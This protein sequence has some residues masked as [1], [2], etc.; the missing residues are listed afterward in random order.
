MEPGKYLCIDESMCQWLGK[1]MPNIK[2]VPRKP[3]PIGQEYK[4]IADSDTY[5]ILRLDFVSDKF[6]KKFDDTNRTLV[7]TVKRLTE[8][9]F[10]SGRT[11]IADSWFGSPELQDEMRYHGLYSIMQV[12]K[13]RYWPRGMPKDVD[14]ISDLGK[15]FGSTLSMVRITETGGVLIAAS[16]RDKKVKAIVGTCSTTT[17]ASNKRTFRDANGRK[18]TID[19]PRIFDEYETKKSKCFFN[20]NKL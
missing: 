4:T 7:A 9:W 3:H 11:L 20:L 15:E 14:M 17:N 10:Y 8:P 19:R 12:C 13:R 6:Q 5:C 1:D 2:N 16:Y 18:V